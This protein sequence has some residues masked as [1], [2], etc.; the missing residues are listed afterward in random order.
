MFLRANILSSFCSWK[1]S[2]SPAGLERP[3]DFQ[4]H[5][6]DFHKVTFIEINTKYLIQFLSIMS[7]ERS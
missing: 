5:P 3:F 7:T 1:R 2:I 6:F 4:W